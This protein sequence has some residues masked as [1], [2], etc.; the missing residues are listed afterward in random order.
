MRF[1]HRQ[2]LAGAAIFATLAGSLGFYLASSGTVAPPIQVA[3]GTPSNGNF[4]TLTSV[5]GNVTGITGFGAAVSGAFPLARFTTSYAS[6]QTLKVDVYWLNPNT[7]TGYL[8]LGF[9][10]VGAYQ[11]VHAGA[12]VT[13]PN[14]T[15]TAPD[16]TLVTTSVTYCAVLVNASGSTLT[17]TSKL[18]LSRHIL[19]GY[20][21]ASGA[22][23]TS[24]VPTCTGIAATTYKTR[25]TNKTPCRP[26]TI[27]T[28]STAAVYICAVA[29]NHGGNVPGQTTSTVGPLKFTIIG[30]RQ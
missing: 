17:A 10:S 8:K 30:V 27:T 11:V 4:A 3:S 16:V 14:K 28:T 26:A 18:I 21:V 15:P 22:T 6:V 1:G 12:C 24:P 9:L 2:L 23:G 25:Q 5:A 7:A 20:L 13:A 19:G 29:V